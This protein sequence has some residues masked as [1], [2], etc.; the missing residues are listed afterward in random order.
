MR[1]QRFEGYEGVTFVCSLEKWDGSHCGTYEKVSETFIPSPAGIV[2]SSVARQRWHHLRRQRYVEPTAGRGNFAI[3]GASVRNADGA[4]VLF[5]D[6][7]SAGGG[8][9]QINGGAASGAGHGDVDL[10]SFNCR[11]RDAHRTPVS[12]EVKPPSSVICR[13]RCANR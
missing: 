12:A 7:S 13:L 1:L 9:F 6:D 10:L 4:G 3:D 11:S 5:F 8:N 2:C